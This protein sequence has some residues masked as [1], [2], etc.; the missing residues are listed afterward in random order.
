MFIHVRVYVYINIIMYSCPFSLHYD[1]ISFF[2]NGS[3]LPPLL[4]SPCQGEHITSQQF[5]ENTFSALRPLHQW[6]PARDEDIT[7]FFAG[8][9][10]AP[11]PVKE[12]ADK[13]G[14]V[15]GR[16]GSE[17]EQEEGKERLEPPKPKRSRSDV[18]A[19]HVRRLQVTPL[20]H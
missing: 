12:E 4:P 2:P 11:E 7:S 5:V 16:R 18:R 1:T 20:L 6:M 9:P 8:E 10:P 19:I 13:E 3:S 15:D 14:E 17:E